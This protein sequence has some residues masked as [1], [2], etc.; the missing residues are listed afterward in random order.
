MEDKRLNTEIDS[1]LHSSAQNK[2][3]SNVLKNETKRFSSLV[4]SN[5]INSIE[6]KK[7]YFKIFLLT[8]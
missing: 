4:L 2:Y 7:I 1:S 6:D 3:F 5:S 8:L